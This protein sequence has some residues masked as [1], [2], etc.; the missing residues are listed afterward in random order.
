GPR[1]PRE[2]I[3]SDAQAEVY[4]VTALRNYQRDLYRRG[5][6]LT[7]MDVNDPVNEPLVA[8]GAGEMRAPTTSALEEILEAERLHL[9]DRATSVLYDEALPTLAE[10]LRDPAKFRQT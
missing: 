1:G 5:R 4:L 3:Q 9:V 7:S 10:S 6:R 8:Y 2:M